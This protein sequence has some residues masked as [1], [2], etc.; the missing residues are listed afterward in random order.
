MNYILPAATWKKFSTWGPRVKFSIHSKYLQ[1]IC[2]S[3][4]Q[5]KSV[6]ISGRKRSHK[7]T[8]FFSLSINFLVQV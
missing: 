4:A 3:K 5:N 1:H 6:N 8:F 2:I 7:G